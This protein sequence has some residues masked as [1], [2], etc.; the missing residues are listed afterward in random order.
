MDH[1]PRP[2]TGTGNLKRG[3]VIR[4]RPLAWMR[5]GREVARTPSG[6]QHHIEYG[7]QRAT[8]VEVGG[9]LRIYEVDGFPVVDGYAEEE[10]AP[11]GRGQVLIPWPN[12]LAGGLYRFGE[13]TH[14]VPL[15]EP[16]QH[17]AIHGLVRW[18]AWDLIDAS[19]RRVRLGHMLWPQAGYPFTLALE[20]VYE[21]SDVGLRVTITAENAGKDPAP[22]GA[23][24][25]PYIRAELTSLDTSVL[26]LPAETWLETD[27]RQIPTGR[28]L[29]TAGTEYDFGTPR[30]IGSTRLDT[31]FTGLGREGDGLA[32][33]ELT[34][35]D[36][37]RT[38]AMWLD[39]AFDYVMAFTGDTLDEAARR[40]SIALE[41]MTCAPDAFRNCMGIQVLE[42]GQRVSASWGL[43]MGTHST[44]A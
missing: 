36:R 12:R 37:R 24:Q 30:T 34:S 44:G 10:M 20:L 17:N 19:P 7:S 31:A 23:G 21:M 9:G 40:R 29:S 16:A 38:V 26:H 18:S 35:S 41:P 32:W 14:Q 4:S 6:R 5:K 1:P 28:L 27:D 13:E 39:S 25:H 22:Y 2:Y 15:S 8:V 33:I 3:A 11:A 42:P 43:A